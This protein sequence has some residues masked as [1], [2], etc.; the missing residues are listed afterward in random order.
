VVIDRYIWRA[1]V[2]HHAGR[3]PVLDAAACERAGEARDETVHRTAADLQVDRGGGVI[4]II[5]NRRAV[6]VV[7]GIAAPVLLVGELPAQTVDIAAG[8]LER[9]IAE[10][11]IKRAVLEHQD[12]DVLDLLQVGHAAPLG[13]YR[14]L[15]PSPANNPGGR[16]RPSAKAAA[17]HCDEHAAT[18]TACR[19]GQLTLGG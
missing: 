4:G 14:A 12:D 19:P 7:D 5:G 2:A 18:L 15:G 11:V 13:T 1:V 6:E 8:A 17:T 16:S 3:I 9:E 10:H